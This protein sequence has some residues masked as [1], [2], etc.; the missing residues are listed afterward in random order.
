MWG[1]GG[2]RLLCGEGRG[3]SLVCGGVLVCL[4]GGEGF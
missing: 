4:R 3:G 1:R 2:E